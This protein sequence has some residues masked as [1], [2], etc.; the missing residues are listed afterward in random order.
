MVRYHDMPSKNHGASRARVN[1]LDD[2]GCWNYY[3]KVA[4]WVA[5]VVDMH[6]SLL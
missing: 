4:D 3:W 1:Q 6:A 5:L 2:V